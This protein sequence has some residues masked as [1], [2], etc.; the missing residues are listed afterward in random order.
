LEETFMAESPW[1]TIHAE[2]AA[3]A[4]DL[5]DL[6]SAQWESPSLCEG[7]SVHQVLAH[8]VATAKMTPGKFFAKF[9]GSGFKF[10][11]L[12]DK[13]IAAESSGGPAATLAA[14][15]A[16]QTSTKSPPGPKDSWLG[17]ALVHSEDIRRPLGIAR[18]YPLPWVTRA[19][20]FYA[21]SNAI[22]GGK[23]RVAGLTLKA[24]DADWSRGTGPLVEGP[25]TALLLATC[26]RKVA[27]DD[28]TGPGLDTLRGR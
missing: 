2:R 20:D 25:A 27:L 23:K 19:I 9:A 11:T 5:A 17:E 18:N 7:W 14:F 24:T 22:I 4:A 6:T 1:P 28:L 12:A 8:Q 13:E 26:G 10:A 21:N 15:R 3:L 16:V